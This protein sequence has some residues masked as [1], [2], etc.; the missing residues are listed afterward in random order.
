MTAETRP[1]LRLGF[2]GL[3]VGAG[4]FLRSIEH[5]PRVKVVAAAEVR[6]QALETFAR[7][8]GGRT[9][10]SVEALCA[11]PDVDVV[12]IATPNYLHRE[13]ALLAAA[14]R[15][16]IIC[17]KPMALTVEECAEMCEAAER[18]GVALLCGQTYSM[19]SDIQAMARVAASGRLGRVIAIAMMMS[20]D[21]LLKPRVPEEL[22]E[23]LGGGVLYRHGPHLVDTARVLAGTR[24][25]SVRGS[26][27]RWMPERP[28]AGNFSAFLSFEDGT[29]AT[30]AYNGYGY[31]D[32][33]ELTWGIGNRQ[34]SDAERIAV[35][36][37]LRDGTSDGASG[38]EATRFGAP[39]EAPPLDDPNDVNKVSPW[40]GVT[41]VSCERGDIRQSP[42][43]IFVYDDDGRHEIEVKL[44][45]IG[46]PDVRELDD[47]LT[48]GKPLT[49]DGRW[50]L[51]TLEACTA[52]LRSSEERRE[53]VL[54]HQGASS[55]A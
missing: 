33:S 18:N 34:Y 22:D 46:L 1:P 48:N 23:S 51:A 11:D 55:F 30:I 47:Y 28:C 45:P 16:H 25:Q 26:V 27:G 12:W 35:R 36:R 50:A 49:H 17:T 2:A 31:F 14:H 7:R 3:G 39:G 29:P 21:W 9:Y 15:K 10:D 6:P 19:S 42:H 53:I 37:E 5:E 38:K 20:G 8:Y 4:M 54:E 13:H 40:F 41:V 32:T 52:I 24:L 43:G 44:E